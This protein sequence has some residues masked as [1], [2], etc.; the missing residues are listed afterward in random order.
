MSQFFG[1][2]IPPLQVEVGTRVHDEACPKRAKRRRQREAAA[3][4]TND[5]RSAE[6]ADH[7]ERRTP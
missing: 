2:P 1:L 4:R 6:D 7:N 3:T 5:I